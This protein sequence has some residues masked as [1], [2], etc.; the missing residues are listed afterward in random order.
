MNTASFM[1][2]SS[3][4]ESSYSAR[5]GGMNLAEPRF[6]GATAQETQNEADADADEA[7]KFE[8]T[9]ARSAARRD[10]RA[11]CSARRERPGMR[12]RRRHGD[13][14]ALARRRAGAGAKSRGDHVAHL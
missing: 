9:G 4:D 8:N 13:R 7:D 14:G 11:G 10:G 12:R 1:K 5:D 3:R 2:P 6:A